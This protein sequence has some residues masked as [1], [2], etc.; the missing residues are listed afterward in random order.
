MEIQRNVLFR[1]LS[2]LIPMLLVFSVQK[3][4]VWIFIHGAVILG[5]SIYLTLEKG[6]RI[7]N[8]IRMV[9]AQAS[10]LFLQKT[11]HMI[12]DQFILL[13]IG[14]LIGNTLLFLF[15]PYAFKAYAMHGPDFFGNQNRV[16]HDCPEKKWKPT[17]K[18]D[19]ASILVSLKKNE[20]DCF[21]LNSI[22][23]YIDEEKAKW[24]SPFY[25]ACKSGNLIFVDALLSKVNME[26]NS[27]ETDENGWNI[28]H[29][30]FA[31]D[32]IALF[33]FLQPYKVSVESLR[34]LCC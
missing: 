7:M 33:N 32:N 23:S 29:H 15:L 22:Q 13:S 1:S 3:G 12:T 19:W 31:Q 16:Y 2:L 18:K 9:I 8:I 27:Y 17:S 6:N 24:I 4:D 11:S 5:F 25:Y 30:T 21:L 26:D 20:T 14:V 28:M 34:E 10:A